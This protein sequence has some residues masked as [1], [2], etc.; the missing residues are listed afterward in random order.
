MS[1]SVWISALFVLAC[2]LATRGAEAPA[3]PPLPEG[4]AGIA[5]RHPGDA[6]IERNPAVLL[7]DGF[8]EAATAK[9]LYRK[10]DVVFQEHCIRIARDAANV[11][12]GSRALE[13]TVPQQKAELSNAVNK[14]LKDER[15]ALFLRYYSKFEAGFNQ[16]GSSHNGGHIS[17]HYFLDGRATPGLRAD[18]RNKFLALFENWRG[19]AST[20]SPGHLNIYCY[21]PE[22]R[23]R[24]GDHFFPTGMVLPNTSV[25]GN[26]GPAF[27]PRPDVVPDLDRW[28][29]FEFMVRANTPGRRDG[30]LATWVDGKLIGDFP[31]L[32]LRDVETLKIDRFGLE[33]H[34]GTNPVR[35]NKKWYDDVVAATEYI[36][37]MTQP[38]GPGEPDRT[39]N[40]R[41]P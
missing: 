26:F 20:P 13:F 9:D 5:A 23:D 35:P 27:V 17:G 38:R 22:Q 2:A 25:R 14:I 32:R 34:M 4:D 7:H 30:R 31:N 21:H 16:V 24:Y 6:G 41:Q 36:G 19:E 33:L 15:D 1:R 8:E 39:R 3:L 37:P 40:S 11:H 29:C 28:Y 18:G 12:S 10:W